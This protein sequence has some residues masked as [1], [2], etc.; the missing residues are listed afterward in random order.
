[1][2][3]S[4]PVRQEMQN[5]PGSV[6]VYNSSSGNVTILR[7]PDGRVYINGVLTVP[8]ESTRDQNTAPAFSPS[9]SQSPEPGLWDQI[10]ERLSNHA[11]LQMGGGENYENK[12]WGKN[13]CAPGQTGKQEHGDIFGRKQGPVYTT[14]QGSSY[15]SPQA[16]YGGSQSSKSGNNASP[17]EYRRQYFGGFF[18]QRR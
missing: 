18:G 3:S 11:H 15:W 17:I 1:M 8:G 9:T 2:R 5:S 10:K 4:P 12:P 16:V 14:G 7:L 6:Q 13:S